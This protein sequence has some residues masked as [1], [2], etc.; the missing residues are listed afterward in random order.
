[1][2]LD[3]TR[4]EEIMTTLALHERWKEAYEALDAHCIEL[5]PAYDEAVTRAEKAETKLELAQ[6]ELQARLDA[7]VDFIPPPI[8][9]AVWLMGIGV[10]TNIEVCRKVLDYIKESIVKV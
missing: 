7:V 10:S 5:Y 4:R 9:L 1:M 8:D 6:A 3:M 2:K